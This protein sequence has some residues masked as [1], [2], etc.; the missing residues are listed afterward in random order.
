MVAVETIPLACACGNIKLCS[1]RVN[2]IT[3]YNMV[4]KI[5]MSLDDII[6]SNK[7][8]R[9]GGKRGSGG[10]GGAPRRGG[11]RGQ[12]SGGGVQRG[13]NRGGIT[14]AYTRVNTRFVTFH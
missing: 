6:K 9:F 11:F 2:F 14:R 1:F 13:R 7:P 3:N 12:R 5:D 4:D 8:R 10:R